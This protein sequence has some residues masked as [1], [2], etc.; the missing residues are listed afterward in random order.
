MLNKKFF[1]SLAAGAVIAAAF[2]S[3]PAKADLPVVTVDLPKIGITV[4][5]S[6]IDGTLTEVSKTA[7]TV[8]NYKRQEAVTAFVP[9]D[10]LATT[11]L[12]EEFKPGENVKIRYKVEQNGMRTLVKIKHI[13]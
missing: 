10:K 4:G 13:K 1:I 7:V 2:S 12:E 6:V 3:A 11:N 9:Q 8:V 5:A